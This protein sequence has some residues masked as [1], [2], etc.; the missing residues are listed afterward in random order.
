[1]PDQVNIPRQCAQCGTP[2][3]TSPG[4]LE[5]GRG[6]FCSRS[7]VAKSSRR[8]PTVRF[9]ENVD[10]SGDG[11]WTWLKSTTSGYGAFWDG[12]RL[13]KAHRYS[14]ALAYGSVPDELHVCHHCDN[15]PCVRPDHLFL[16]TDAD[17]LADMARKRRSTIGERNPRAVLTR[18][19][20]EEIRARYVPKRGAF[21]ELAR[22]YNI[23]PGHARDIV[24][25]KR[26]RHV[27]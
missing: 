13:V 24:L 26:W 25:R 27:A 1:M 14:Y 23:S 7:C 16:G 19:I 5:R 3:L 2:F 8:D 18:Q 21:N 20:V 10:R 11:C 17:N 9:W 15:P 6:V 12:I 22:L 4:A